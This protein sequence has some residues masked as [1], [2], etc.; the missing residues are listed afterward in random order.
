MAKTITQLPAAAS[1]TTQYVMAADNPAGTATEK[2][3]IGQAIA[4]ALPPSA[5][6]TGV[7]ITWTGTLYSGAWS[8]PITWTPPTQS[9]Q[10]GNLFFSASGP[11]PNVPAVFVNEYSTAGSL[12]ISG[13]QVV[14]NI[15]NNRQ[16]QADNTLTGISLPD[17]EVAYGVILAGNGTYNLLTSIS[18][19]KLRY[20]SLGQGCSIHSVTTLDLPE[21]E[22]APFGLNVSGNA[23]TSVSLPK[24]KKAENG[25][26]L[27]STSLTSLAL[28]ALE[29]AAV[30]I[31]SASLTSLSV[32]SLRISGFNLN[33]SALTSLT[34]PPLGQWKRMIFLQIAAPIPQATVDDLLAH[35][36]LM[37]GS[38]GTVL[39]SGSV[40][41]TG[42]SAAP[43][44][45]GSTTVAGSSF[46]CSGTTCTVNWTGHGY[47]TGDVLRVSGITTATNANRYAKITVVN[48]NQ[49]TY[50]ISS[51]SAT[52][53]GTATVRKAGADVNALVTRGVTLTTN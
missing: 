26:Q 10:W 21:L 50:T 29:D 30:T 4:P 13:A 16:F 47:A 22:L 7:A 11:V 18:L 39:Y 35:V 1:P 6:P 8:M 34:L 41:L 49:F 9:F 20:G 53:G 5:P 17:T 2:V 31:N 24:L 33:A 25:F 45:L 15:W 14:N 46:V 51:Q 28:P 43:S 40:Q 48:A 37:D 36:A 44:D 42:A 23:L 38:G 12:T 52:G 27:A 32:P 3:T 19:P